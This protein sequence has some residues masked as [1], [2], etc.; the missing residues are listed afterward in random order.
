[1]EPYR[2]YRP[3]AQWEIGNCYFDQGQYAQALQAYRDTKEKYPFQSWCGNGQAEAEH[4]YAYYVGLCHE[5][6]GETNAAVEDYLDAVEID[7]AGLSFSPQPHLRIV[8]I[9]AEAGQ[10]SRL[11]SLLDDMM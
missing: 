3:R 7:A 11:N 1:M 9:Y 6:L 10:M 8:E 5:Y 2:N 4:R